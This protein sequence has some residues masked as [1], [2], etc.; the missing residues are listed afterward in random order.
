MTIIY[1]LLMLVMLVFAGLQYNDP[2]NFLWISVYVVPAIALALAAFAP[3]YFATIVGR[4]LLFVTVIGLALG[5]Y[6]LWPSQLSSFAVAEWW[7]NERV[8]EGF[9]MAIAYLFT[10]LTIPLAFRR[11]VRRLKPRRQ[12]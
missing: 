3:H 4:I 5:V 7:E 6:A 10:C 2:D 9:G 12:E 1:A 8:K 11:S